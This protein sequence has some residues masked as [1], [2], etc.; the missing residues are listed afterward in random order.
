[1]LKELLQMV[2]K[3]IIQPTG[4]EVY[5]MIKYIV[6]KEEG[7]TKAYFKDPWGKSIIHTIGKQFG[8]KYLN[9]DLKKRLLHYI[10]SQPND[11]IVTCKEDFDENKGKEMAKAKLLKRYYHALYKCYR[12]V[13][14]YHKNRAEEAKAMF[15]HFAS[16]ACKKSFASRKELLCD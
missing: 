14:D 16:K 7:T 6:N 12:M 15:V 8:K 2:M 1:M 11:A 5:I 9:S 4:K 3:Y 13:S 10:S